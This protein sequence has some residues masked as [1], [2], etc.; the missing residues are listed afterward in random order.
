MTI[1]LV[2]RK[3]LAVLLY[4][5][6]G[7]AIVLSFRFAPLPSPP[8]LVFCTFLVFIASLASLRLPGGRWEYIPVYPP[9]LVS[10]LMLGPFAWIPAVLPVLAFRLTAGILRKAVV[11]R[12]YPHPLHLAL[13][14]LV[15]GFF[16]RAA[17]GI[18]SF[19]SIDRL[20]IFPLL[21]SIVLFFA[22]SLWE[23]PYS[24]LARG[25]GTLAFRHYD[26]RGRLV[27]LSL[28]PLGILAVVLEARWGPL[29]VLF[30]VIPLV[31]V[32]FFLK[33]AFADAEK[34]DDL[35]V[36]YRYTTLISSSLTRGDVLKSLADE[37]TEVAQLDGVIVL[38]H[39]EGAGDASFHAGK[40]ALA[41]LPLSS[42]LAQFA[43][44]G[45]SPVMA[46]EVIARGDL[47][48]DLAHHVSEGKELTLT[49]VG[50][51]DNLRGALFAL[52]DHFSDK[53]RQYLGIGASQASSAIINAELYKE[54][55]IA[56]ERLKEAQARLI[57]S[58][59]I[60][61]VGQLAA[62]VAHEL[63]NPLGAVLT[64]IQTLAPFLEGRDD[65]KENLGEAEGAVL[66]CKLIIEKLLRYS[67][68][69]DAPPGPV[70]LRAVVKD[71][72]ELV[73]DHF[74]LS[75]III[76]ENLGETPAVTANPNHITQMVTN[77]LMN[78]YD[79]IVEKGS[80]SGTLEVRCGL[81]E[82][83]VFFSV[84]DDGAG[85]SEEVMKSAFQPFFTTK[86]M[87][88][89]AGLGLSISQDIV[90]KYGGTIEAASKL[91]EG[92]LFTVR[93]PVRQEESRRNVEEDCT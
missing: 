90:R 9:L 41:D 84:G 66:Q 22:L 51:G 67:R 85:M 86:G 93:I 36:F 3:L 19:G 77:V 57:Q 74:S 37:I 39:R 58:S 87:G 33:K 54:A 55:V 16:F 73:E 14:S 50:E 32:Y 28:A 75:N 91:H 59:R 83:G 17:G 79:A 92:S 70:D 21:A 34:K 53:D 64:N 78:A 40:G 2:P 31:L 68:Q 4:L 24:S 48:P 63:N 71:S 82:S 6:C 52:K 42:A 38:L 60:A 18:L 29:Y 10:V 45:N 81:E 56:N 69:A 12:G 27:D 44:R 30:I 46:T 62:G 23:L 15:S 43:R 5:L 76:R 89:A 49:A 88:K 7:V 25:K 47:V 35:N 65:L 8:R 61:A 11:P 72:L 13:V 80:G 20:V 1:P 26:R